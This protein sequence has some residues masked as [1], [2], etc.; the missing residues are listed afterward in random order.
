[1]KR[2]LLLVVLVILL[3][4]CAPIQVQVQPTSEPSPIPTSVPCSVQAEAYIEAIDEIAQEWDD[5]RNLAGSTP[6]MSLAP[7]ISDLQEIR[8]KVDKLD[9][10]SCAESVH[11]LLIQHMD[12][13]I[14][15]FLK[16]LAQESDSIVNAKFTEASMAFDQWIEEY[17]KLMD[18]EPPYD[19]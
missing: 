17:G 1:M 7:A 13:V 10:P 5:A 9:R 3:T 19:Q 14:D 15:A 11:S 4:G 8:R 12:A 16:F 6:R 18:G 2:I